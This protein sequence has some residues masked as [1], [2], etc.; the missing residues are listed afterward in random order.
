MSDQEHD[1]QHLRGRED[2]NTTQDSADQNGLGAPRDEPPHDSDNEENTDPQRDVLA[3]FFVA[4]GYPDSF[5]EGLTGF[6]RNEGERN[7]DTEQHN[8]GAGEAFPEGGVDNGDDEPQRGQRNEHNHG[9][10]D[11]RMDG[12][13]GDDVE[14]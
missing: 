3:Q 11:Q 7:G 10:N 13:S 5:G 1:N 8:Q 14:K 6:L 4:L 12:K 2:E 9:V